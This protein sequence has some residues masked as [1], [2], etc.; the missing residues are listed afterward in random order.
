MITTRI[1]IQTTN[2]AVPV[3]DWTASLSMQ[4]ALQGAF[5]ADAA[6]FRLLDQPVGAHEDGLRHRKADRL[7]V[8]QIDRQVEPLRLVYRNFRRVFTLQNSADQ[9]SHAVKN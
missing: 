6:A 2:P 1:R 9:L 8:L 7:R 3:S 4:G 5:L